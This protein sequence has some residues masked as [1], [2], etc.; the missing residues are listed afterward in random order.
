MVDVVDSDFRISLIFQHGDLVQLT[1]PH[2]SVAR[3]MLLDFV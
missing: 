1:F 3:A 2:D